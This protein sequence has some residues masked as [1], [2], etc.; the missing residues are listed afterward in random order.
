MGNY[1]QQPLADFKYPFAELRA[2][3]LPEL[4]FTENV[5]SI[6][7]TIQVTNADTSV[8][9]PNWQKLAQ[10]VTTEVYAQQ[11]DATTLTFSFIPVLPS[12]S[13][14]GV[15][16]E[17]STS[18]L[19]QSIEVAVTIES[20]NQPLILYLND[21]FIFFTPTSQKSYLG[22]LF[23]DYSSGT[24]LELFTSEANFRTPL[25]SKNPGTTAR[26]CM[27]GSKSPGISANL[28]KGQLHL[29]GDSGIACITDGDFITT[30]ADGLLALSYD[31]VADQPQTITKVCILQPGTAG[32]LNEE[33]PYLRTANP[34]SQWFF[35]VERVVQPIDFNVTFEVETNGTP[36]HVTYTNTQALFYPK[37]ADVALNQEQITSLSPSQQIFPLIEGENTIE[38][39]Q[40]FGFENKLLD[41]YN[42]SA[43][44]RVENCSDK[45]IVLGKTT[46]RGY[47]YAATDKAIACEFFRFPAANARQDYVLTIGANN[48]QGKQMN[49][50][51]SEQGAASDNYLEEIFD[52]KVETKYL[53]LFGDRR[54]DGASVLLQTPS[55]G[56]TSAINELTRLSLSPFPLSWASEI[57]VT[58]QKAEAFNPVGL[59]EVKRNA[60][61]WYSAE[62]LNPSNSKQVLQL[63][64]SYDDGWMLW[65]TPKNKFS[66]SETIDHLRYNNW[67]NAWLI[68]S[69]HYSVTILYWPQLLIFAG[70]GLLALLIGF[71]CWVIFTNKKYVL[72]FKK[73]PFLFMKSRMILLGKKVF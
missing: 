30:P 17:L 18:I 13:I 31:F 4:T 21:Q 35:E 7:K 32:C 68:P 45:G 19:N 38:V 51:V 65:A 16:R 15:K 10:G 36:R 1:V 34:T 72:A 49:F 50:I 39:Q 40:S 67:A 73:R 59:S 12:L 52:K 69:G 2:E 63:L 20:T 70:Y 24:K 11:T 56:D 47:Q 27:D 5:S 9:L 33:I 44:S 41:T 42:L 25:F 3:Q 8:I 46:D 66:S 71:F 53:G 61:F 26:N 57:A 64:Q 43:P 29:S 62:V 37:V 54:Y 58:T 22:A 14:N 23:L 28:E 48:L 55:F 60:N 6:S